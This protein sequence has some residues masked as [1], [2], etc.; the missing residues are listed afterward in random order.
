MLERKKG[1]K[2]NPLQT[3]RLLPR[4]RERRPSI[5]SFPTLALSP[6]ALSCCRMFVLVRTPQA[7]FLPAA[8]PRRSMG[9]SDTV[10]G[11]GDMGLLK[12]AQVKGILTFGNQV[13]RIIL[14]L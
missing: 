14:L 3:D 12:L 11:M 13:Q 6:L 10:R 7:A 8:R 1:K 2:D 9:H 5:F 4:D